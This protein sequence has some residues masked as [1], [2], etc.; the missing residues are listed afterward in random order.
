MVP[1]SGLINK[2]VEYV[3]ASFANDLARWC[4]SLLQ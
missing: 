3:N 1:W 4:L 2:V